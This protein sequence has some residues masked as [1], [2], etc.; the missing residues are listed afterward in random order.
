MGDAYQDELGGGVVLFVDTHAGKGPPV[1]GPPITL[2]ERS[3]KGAQEPTRPD[4]GIYMDFGDHDG[5]GD[6]DLVVG[7]YSHWTPK[8]WTLT[9]GQQA[10]AAELKQAVAKTDQQMEAFYDAIEK[11]LEGLD[12]AAA[13]KK[14][15][16]LFAERRAKLVEL[17][18]QRKALD[19]ELDPLVPG[20]KRKSFVWLYENQGA[21]GRP[22]APPR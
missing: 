17:N 22:A 6:L 5:D 9:P 19:E 8:P 21:S 1:F 13:D 11:A 2:I 4:S 16:E 15:G 10:R 12:E 3:K 7:G 20:S 18:K 14:R